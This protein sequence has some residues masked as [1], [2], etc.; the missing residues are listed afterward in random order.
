MEFGGPQARGAPVTRVLPLEQAPARS[1]GGVARL[2]FKVALACAG[3]LL[4]V[5]A[6]QMLKAGCRDYG[7]AVIGVLAVSNP[8]DALGFG[9]LLAYVFLSGSP[10][11]AVAV[12]FLAAGTIDGTQAFTMITGSRLGASFIVLFVGF[13]YHLR[14]HERGASVSIGVLALLTTA[15]IYLPAMALGYWILQTDLLLHL[16]VSPA[17]EITGL[18]DRLTDPALAWTKDRVATWALIPMGIAAMLGAFKLLDLALPQVSPEGRTLHRLGRLIYRPAAMFL[19]GAAVTTV[20]LSVSVSLSVLVP[21]SARGLIRRENAIPYIMGANITTFVDTLF[22][23][24]V[25]GGPEAFGIVLVEMVSVAVLSLL[26][27]GLCYRRFEEALTCTQTWIV[28]DNL[29]LMA[30]LALML[31]IPLALLAF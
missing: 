12:S 29:R 20:T 11:A 25:A 5:M 4:F 8:V 19:V 18:M 2:L 9:W 21:L 15:A 14:G 13:L 6:L 1:Q 31:V 7:T 28:Q 17:G 23:A 22:V 30:F 10:V 16:K 26:V 3:L 27:L 24:L